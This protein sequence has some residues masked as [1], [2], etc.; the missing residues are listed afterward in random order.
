L[1]AK[2]FASAEFRIS[3]TVGKTPIHMTVAK[4]AGRWGDSPL[5]GKNVDAELVR[6]I[7][8]IRELLLALSSATGLPAS[9]YLPTV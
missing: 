6:E 1:Y 3:V 5:F 9:L 8:D 4:D 2:P 7:G